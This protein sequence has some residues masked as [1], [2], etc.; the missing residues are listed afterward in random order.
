MNDWTKNVSR[1]HILN[2]SINIMEDL[3]DYLAIELDKNLLKDEINKE[4]IKNLYRPTIYLTISI[5]LERFIRVMSLNDNSKNPHI[6]KKKFNNFENSLDCFLKCYYDK[7]TNNNLLINLSII[8]NKKF[9]ENTNYKEVNNSIIKNFFY[10]NNDSNFIYF[11]NILSKISKRLLEKN[12]LRRNNNIVYDGSVFLENIFKKSIRFK[13]YKS[14]IKKNY[15]NQF[16][17]KLQKYIKVIF[18]KN[19][20][21]DKIIK[22]DKNILEKISYLFSEWITSAIPFSLL[23]ELD[24]KINYYSKTY[25]FKNINEVHATTSLLHNDNFKIFAAIY[26]SKGKPLIVHDHGVN[27]FIKYFNNDGT[28]KFTKMMPLLYFSDYYLAWGKNVK[29]NQWERVEENLKTKIIN[30]G[31]NYLMQ[32]KPKKIF[33]INKNNKIRI[34]YPSSPFKFYMTCLDEITPEKNLLHK[35]QVSEFIEHILKE[36]NAEIVFKNFNSKFINYKN[37]PTVNYLYKYLIKGK[38]KLTNDKPIKIMKEFDLLLLDM[39]STTF[40]ESVA[41]GVP[42]LIFSNKFDYSLLC[43]DG[44][45]IN[46]NLEKNNILFYEKNNAF[47]CFKYFINNK[48]SYFVK[49]KDLFIDYQNKIAYPVSTK[50][51]KSKLN[52][53]RYNF[54]K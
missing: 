17:E 7:K 44:K 4:N 21:N 2:L 14:Q 6:E 5:F 12:I 34:F 9:V 11:K 51:F 1:Y 49:N 24:N 41:I 38:I 54:L 50:E 22:I 53:F 43:K 27:N 29:V 19:L 8:L 20:I 28:Y 46:D 52:S 40:A 30:L 23:E 15:N 16:R 45:I 35:L 36:Y 33:N 13:D 42:S 18:F 48:N 10:K 47:K 32:I 25:N 31:S 26:K 3:L 37:D 39:V